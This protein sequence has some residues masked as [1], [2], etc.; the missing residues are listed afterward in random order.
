MRKARGFT[1]VEVILYLGLF[2]L[3]GMALFTFAWDS[4]ELARKS[5][6]ERAVAAEARFVVERIKFILRNGTGVNEEES[7][8]DDPEGRLVVGII[9][10]GDTMTLESENGH[11]V[12]RQSNRDT[13]TL[14]DEDFIG[15]LSNIERY[16]LSD[17]RVGFIGYTVTL[18]TPPGS[19]VEYT[20]EFQIQTGVMIR[21]LG[22]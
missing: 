13:V 7:V 6:T 20:T 19:S 3:L 17:G 21:N 5:H 2:S 22:L 10:T 11:I 18:R 12:L 9:D 14:H 15:E 4:L 1:F 8:W 16:R